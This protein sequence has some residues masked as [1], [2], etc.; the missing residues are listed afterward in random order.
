MKKIYLLILS[1]V[2]ISAAQ[3]QLTGTK[4]IPGDYADLGAAITD[5]NVQGVGAGG[6]ILNV[7]A[8]NPQTSPAALGTTGGGYVIG[9][10]GSL[11]LTTTSSANP[12]TIQ[13]NG[14]TIT[15][16]TGAS[17]AG[18]VVGQLNDAIIKLVGADWITITGFTLRENPGNTVTA[19]ATNTM[20]E[21]GIA[22]FYASATDGSQNNTIQNNTISLSRLYQNS[23]GIYSNVRH[24]TTSITTSAEVATSA[25]G[26]NSFN[27]VYTNAIN[28][29]NYGIVF[30][31]AVTTLAAIDNGNDIGGSTAATG[32]TLTNWGVLGTA[33]SGYISVSGANSG[34]IMHQ[35]INDNIS[36][37]TITSFAGAAS[38]VMVAITL[39]GI[40]KTYAATPTGTITSNITNNTITVTSAPTTGFCQAIS[41][42]GLAALATSTLNINNNII[43]NCAITGA[44]ATTG[45]LVG[46]TNSS[47][48]GTLNINNNII[49]GSTRT[50]TT[51]QVQ[52]I[53]N[54]GSIV[55]TININNNQFGTA[56]ADY[57]NITTASSG[58]VFAINSSAAA[59]T[60]NVTVQNN[61]V[62]KI[63][64]T[65]AGTSAHSYISVAGTPIT[66][67]ISNNTF[68]NLIL[69]TTGS[70]T[71]IAQSYTASAT[72]TKVV[73]GNAIITGF[74]KTGAGGTVTF[75]VDNGSSVAGA[76]S[77]YQNNSI[78]NGT[79]TGATAFIGISCTD[80]GT[81]PT[82]NINNNT[83]NNWT[84][85]AGALTGINVTYLSG[86]GNIIST[87]TI[88]NLNG[89]SSIAGI[90]IG[91]TAATATSVAV[92]TNIINNLNSTGTGGSVTG[93]ACANTS[94]GIN[95]G[96]NQINTLSSTGAANVSGVSISGSTATAVFKNNIYNLSNSN[97]TTTV[98]GIAV[99]AGTLTNAYNN[100]ISD[101]RAPI[102]NAAVPIY[103]INVS[104]GTSVG[105]Y[106]NTI[107]LGKAATLTSAGAQFGVT[108][109]G[110]SSTTNHTLRNNIVW[111]DATPVGTGAIAA[112]R[113]SA[114]GTAGTAP[115]VANFNSNNNIYYVLT[116]TGTSPVVANLNKYLYLEGNVTTTATNGYGIEIGQVDNVA[117][118]LKNDPNFNTS[119]GLYKTFM[120]S[121]ETATFTE[122]NLTAGAG[123]TF[124][125]SGSSFAAE[126]AQ[127]IA[128]PS[129]TDDYS[130]V[131]RSA[132]PDVG[133]LEFTGTG[134]DAAAPSIAF[135]VI[136][137]T[138]CTS[139]P[140]LAAVITDASGINTTLGLAPR[141]Y[142]RKG[143]A[144]AE[145]DVFLNYPTENTNAFNGWKYV[146][147][148][149]TA[150]N[151]SFAVD[152][153]LLQTPMILGDSLT[154]F[155]VAQDLA[156]IPNVGKNSVT[157]P[158]SFC[159]TSVVMPSTG[160]VP[161]SASLGYKI[162]SIATVQPSTAV[163]VA[164]T[165]DNQVLRIDIPASTCYGNI[166]QLNFANVSTAIADISNAK[167]YY[168]TSTIFSTTTPF[169]TAVANPGATFSVT[170]SQ[171]S[172]ASGTNYFWLVYDV[173]CNAP[174]TA[175]NVADASLTDL[176]TS[177]SGT[178]TP[179]TPNPVGTR[180]INSLPGITT[181]QPATTAIV[182]GT[183]DNQV[184]R[185]DLPGGICI[186]NITQLNFA[187]VS[188]AVADIS[189]AK[190]YYTTSTTFST[191]TPFGSA[192]ANP[193]ATFT[194]T[195]SQAST[196]TGTNYFWL[197]YDVACN[198]PATAGNTADA[199]L[200]DVVTSIAGTMIPAIP[201]PVGTRAITVF[202][203]PTATTTQP[204][205]TSVPQGA[206]NAQVLRVDIPGSTCLGNITQLDFTNNSTL[207]TDVTKA[208]VYYTT[209]TTFSNAVQ[210]G[211]DVLA[212]AATFNVTGVQASITSG[213]NYFWL[214]YDVDCAAIAANTIDAGNTAVVATL[215]TYV[216][217]T[218]NPVGTRAIT[219][220]TAGDNIQSAIIAILGSAGGNPYDIVGKSIQTGEPT[221]ILHTQPNSTNGSGQSNYSW[222]TAAGGTQ[223]YRL[224]VPTTGYGSSGNLLIR[225]TTPT[226]TPTADAQVALWKFPNMVAGTCSD[227]ANFT[228]GYMLAA[229]DDAMVTGA[230]YYGASANGFNAVARVRLN[231]G[232]TYYVQIDGFGT[233]LP[234]GDLIIE[235]LADPTGKNV[236]NNGFGAIHN[237]TAVNMRSAS[238]EVIGDDGWT[239]YYNN[240]G[241]ETDIADDVVLMGLN[242]STSPTYLWRGT[243]ATGND[244]MNHVRRIAR[245]SADPI[246]TGPSSATGTDAFVVW[247]GR[248]NAA[249]ASG[250]LALTDGGYV[251]SPNWWMMNKFW[252]VFPNQQP[253]TSIGVRTFYSDADFTALQTVVI[254]GG[255]ALAS[256][257][258]MQFIKATKG[259]A[260]HYTNAET[261]PGSGHAA[262][263][264]GTVTSL[265]WTNTAAVQT[266]INQAQFSINSFSG[267]GGG[268]TGAGSV[269]PYYADKLNGSKQGNINLLDWNVS[270]VGSPFIDITLERSADGRNFTALQQQNATYA[271]C[272]QRFNYTD[273]SPLVGANY[274]RVKIVTPEGK[275]RY[276]TIVVILNKEKGFELIS[277]APNPAIGKATLT[278]TSA[279]A[280]K[281]EI[282]VRDITGKNVS[283]KS[284]T[285]I[286]GNNPID[287]NFATLG[288]GTYSI[289]AINAEGELKTIRFVKY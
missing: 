39:N 35:Q 33:I 220:L 44:A 207:L 144:T 54:S 150:P 247:T 109:I 41:S 162:V 83:I 227:P 108:G 87:N 26:S 198:A 40:T 10:T 103:G 244:L 154:Y 66:N 279:K 95:I 63:F 127:V 11:V 84:T 196:L 277:L 243:N 130:S 166:T 19:A 167:V 9:G 128:A 179:A 251:I 81:S 224:D 270:C 71:F 125:P 152:Y 252:N 210:F 65:V 51:G 209:T 228:G 112:V 258:A 176:V 141:M 183:I 134:V 23:F 99:S 188:T 158:A 219:A 4:N 72:G 31:G 96:S 56:A 286:A 201:N 116:A 259:A 69:N 92:A 246:T 156:A 153:S 200:T 82:K 6:V 260:I 268:S 271:R 257:T 7:L 78:I 186:G 264:L 253:T 261:D 221:P 24:T 12:V 262:I 15:A 234:N 199:S 240:N 180:L 280:G 80:G 275:V 161:T 5:L 20:T 204:L 94:T 17:P 191:I 181:T 32:N 155:V 222:G 163:V 172:A 148:T 61:D 97:A 135:T 146:E 117:L 46:I 43:T 60:C 194:V 74:S 250:D 237:P 88:T 274:Y 13:G 48:F 118:N 276:T 113:R 193:G 132:T 86:A 282:V 211:S 169:G 225:A 126:N 59:A 177:I 100:F 189:N 256:P 272:E 281:I 284:I 254:A 202:V 62:R 79:L 102:A 73:N 105:L 185:I 36:Y 101:L 138:V 55:T 136:P 216:P 173:A 120:G 50:G 157:F 231:P 25:A 98:S 255:G 67:N 175:G 182:A 178:L 203:A 288:A 34:I 68:T 22:L 129:I 91:N 266:A 140:T 205:T 110:Y 248:N 106:Y 1:L 111:I 114:A 28:N 123:N 77:T 273:A 218:A 85:G 187:N 149:G 47:I 160:A 21:F 45:A 215:G 229:N 30:V 213:I 8:G 249:A 287:M 38:G 238:Y 235:D 3:A 57:V 119:C 265:S 174:A 133:A 27:K 263:T 184:L 37:N 42:T 147:A 115:S 195:G 104:G 107:A 197:V 232:Q 217:A 139:A 206:V 208:R 170:G 242:W 226:S 18:H 142:Y 52:G 64:H 283:G 76:V 171:A 230:G 223:W 53:S 49:S 245:I 90:N 233:G 121:R 165:L 212:P 151:F 241:T 29:V 2:L 236:S 267:G 75:I 164:G 93:I 168:T 16:P 143:G 190:V 89:Q 70:V 14:N 159:P 278:L 192:V 289:T 239:Y 131:P 122:N 145:A 214:V 58:A 137:N 285:V 269:L 124:A